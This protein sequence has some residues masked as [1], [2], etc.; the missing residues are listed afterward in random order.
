MIKSVATYP[1]VKE[2]VF[3]MLSLDLKQNASRETRDDFNQRLE[4]YGWSKCPDI[5]TTWTQQF[6][7][8]ENVPVTIMMQVCNSLVAAKGAE[9]VYAY[10]CGNAEVFSKTFLNPNMNKLTYG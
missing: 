6:K 7:D 9:V 4:N 10:Q 1:V 3:V 2:S 5:D 8:I